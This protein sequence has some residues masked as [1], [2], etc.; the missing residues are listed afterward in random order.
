MKA[1]KEFSINLKYKYKFIVLMLYRDILINAIAK[2]KYV[3][4]STFYIPATKIY[5]FNEII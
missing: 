3:I 2:K 1:R 4:K 5:F